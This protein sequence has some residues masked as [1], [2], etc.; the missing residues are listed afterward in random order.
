MMK[1]MIRS[2]IKK[3]FLFFLLPLF[4]HALD[5]R[6]EQGHLTPPAK[7]FL[8]LCDIPSHLEEDQILAF[9]QIHWMQAHKERWEMDENLEEKRDIAL[10]ILRELGCIDSIHAEKNFYDYA[11]V[12]GS[13]G[14]TM[15]RRLDFLFEEWQRG[16]R[17]DQI[18]LL[19][20]QRD[21]DLKLETYPAGL[22]TETDLLIHLFENHP[23]HEI[24]PHIVIDSPKEK[25]ITGILRRPNT[26]N[27]IRDFL[28]TAPK[29]GSCLAISTQPFVGYQ[30][31][32]I[33]YL[34]PPTFSVEAIGPGTE[35]VYPTAD[36]DLDSS[37]VPYPMAI[38]L[39][40]FAKWL[41]YEE[42]RGK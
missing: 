20:G 7:K 39:D 37:K 5:L 1:R 35:N 12:L 14:K 41:L 10:P 33:K 16:V 9:L 13:I 31:A 6:D 19:S 25:G 23:L 30:E 28:S 22:Q 27:T 2:Q 11:L 32:V 4:L 18:I 29:P 42:M 24:A 38:Y 21:L 40:N 34:L 26:A 36:L 17:F 15:K 3:I 8:E